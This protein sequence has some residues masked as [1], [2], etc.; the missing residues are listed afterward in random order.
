MRI[1]FTVLKATARVILDAA[2]IL[3]IIRAVL[4]WFVPPD[5]NR[6]TVFIYKIT[7]IMIWPVRSVVR[8]F[9][10]AERSPVDI[11]FIITV[12]IVALLRILVRA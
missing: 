6:F 1:L 3:L 8:R 9:P 12:V 5:K 11:S 10:S 7:E 4:S 2:E